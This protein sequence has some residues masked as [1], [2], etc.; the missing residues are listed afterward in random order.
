MATFNTMVN[1]K[2]WNA[3]YL[4]QMF[5]GLAHV[6]DEAIIQGLTV[7]DQEAEESLKDP[8]YD[9][10]NF[11]DPIFICGGGHGSEDAF[12]TDIA[13]V[14]YAVFDV[15]NC[16]ILK[17]RVVY[18]HS[19]LTAVNL[20]PA[21]ILNGALAY[22]GYN[23]SWTWLTENADVDPYDLWVAGTFFKSANEFPI[24]LVQGDMVG[25]AKDRCIDEY[26]YWIN[27]WETE[28]SSDKDAA[29]SIKWLLWDRDGLTV[30]GNMSTA[31]VATGILTTL[32]TDIEPPVVAHTGDIITIQGKLLE[33]ETSMALPGKTVKIIQTGKPETVAVTDITGTWSLDLTM[34]KGVTFLYS[35][36]LGDEDYS[37]AYGQ[38]YKIDVGL[39]T[40]DVTKEPPTH[41]ELD[42][43]VYFSGTLIDKATGLGLPGK[44]VTLEGLGIGHTLA[45]SDG[46]G[47]WTLAVSSGI[48]DRPRIYASFVGDESF[49]ESVTE[50][51]QIS[52]GML[53]IFG[54]D[55]KGIGQISGG[56]PG[57][58]IGSTHKILEDGA[59]ENMVAWL[60]II[61]ALHEGWTWEV[62]VNKVKCALYRQDDLSLAGVTHEWE[63]VPF[64]EFTGEVKFPYVDKSLLEIDTEYIFV[65]WLPVMITF[66]VDGVIGYT[67][68]V[69][70]FGLHGESNLISQTKVSYDDFP[71]AFLD[72]I[73]S[74]LGVTA[75]M[76]CEYSPMVAHVEQ[77][78]ELNPGESQPVV[79]EVI[80]K[81]VG[82]YHVSV[83]ELEGTF[84]VK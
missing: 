20:G 9:A 56:W 31:I 74:P 75:S 73:K 66:N 79:F 22:A 28:R 5:Y 78:V 38:T 71:P 16:S 35:L 14:K 19:C 7:I 48:A 43:V 61:S 46:S 67:S 58:I 63:F 65:I 53:P 3:L 4:K 64:T 18:L 36:F 52:I 57:I 50:S 84:T 49:V 2:P 30:L 34:D 69:E 10:I 82:V 80:P 83:N 24:A 54:N 13:D 62:P 6:S 39:T 42:E 33:S 40:I 59:A 12:T 25:V 11:Y 72:P 29:S 17:D 41:A 32:T 23:I 1:I 76:F 70:L 55:I 8:V 60:K 68:A 44:S 77:L 27:I 37:P 81:E 51:Y 45:L 15:F 21:I 47:N 26:N